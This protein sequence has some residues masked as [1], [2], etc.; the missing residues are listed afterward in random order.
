MPQALTAA[1]ADVAH[2]NSDAYTL[3]GGCF[4]PPKD[5]DSRKKR[6]FPSPNRDD[7]QMSDKTPYVNLT[8]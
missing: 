1:P 4:Y 3:D 8:N 5:V 2:Q 7:K 6:H